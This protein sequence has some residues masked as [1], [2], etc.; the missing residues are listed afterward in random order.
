[1]GRHAYLV[2][3]GLAGCLACATALV[4][5]PAQ[6]ETEL[7][8]GFRADGSTAKSEANTRDTYLGLYPELTLTTTADSGWSVELFLAP[9]LY[10]S[11]EDKRPM[12]VDD[13]YALSAVTVTTPAGL[14]FGAEYEASYLRDTEEFLRN[15]Y[16]I[17][18]ETE[19]FGRLTY[20]DF[21]SAVGYR[22]IIAPGGT[23]NFLAD[24]LSS[25]GSCESFGFESTL[26]YTSPLFGRGY[27]IYASLSDPS[28]ADLFEGD[29][30]RT[31]ALALAYGG[32]FLGNSLDYT[33]GL[34][35]VTDFF[36][37]P[38][39][40]GSHA[41]VLQAGAIYVV[42][43]LSYS[44]SGSAQFYEGTDTVQYGLAIGVDWQAT[45]RLLVTG[46]ASHARIADF[47]TAGFPSEHQTTYGLSAEYAIIPDRLSLDIGASRLSAISGDK[48]LIG[49]GF[50]VAIGQG[51]AQPDRPGSL[52]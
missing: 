38:D 29:P 25:F 8:F 39:H 45:D 15:S 51:L 36:G 21:D 14:S 23:T 6:A 42:G 9:E 52:R 19:S 26:L 20:G 12:G 24:E 22:C 31:V 28:D 41:T 37:I 47:A 7:A 34:G 43:D 30:S 3:T 13:P 2:Q 1:M 48:T 40:G 32:D 10:L 44:A 50:S 5:A 16:G 46:G 18:I 27:T 11:S 35:R 17:F 4:A 33:V 49:V